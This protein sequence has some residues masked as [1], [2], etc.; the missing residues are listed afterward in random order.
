M[1]RRGR[2]LALV[3]ISLLWPLFQLS[4]YFGHDYVLCNRDSD[5]HETRECIDGLC[6]TKPEY[7]RCGPPSAGLPDCPSETICDLEVAVCVS[8]NEGDTDVDGGDVG[9]D[10]TDMGADDALEDSGVDT[11]VED[12]C[13]VG[14]PCNTNSQCQRWEECVTG[15]CIAA[16][17]CVAEDQPCDTVT[18][19]TE[20]HAC[21]LDYGRC[22]ERC[23]QTNPLGCDYGRWC[24]PATIPTETHDGVC[25]LGD[26]ND[27]CFNYEDCLEETPFACDVGSGPDTGTCVAF[28]R[29][30]SFCL[31][32]GSRTLAESCAA[33]TD[34]TLSCVAGLR[35]FEGI[36][37][38]P[39]S[40]DD[41]NPESGCQGDPV[42]IPVF[43]HEGANQAG[44]CGVSCEAFSLGQCD[45]DSACAFSVGL[46]SNEATAWFCRSLDSAL[47]VVD[48]G[49]DCSLADPQLDRCV[50]EAYCQ[51]ST[52]DASSGT[53]VQYC[54]PSGAVETGFGLC[55]PLPGGPLLGDVTGSTDHGSATAYHSIEE[56]TASLDVWE[57]VSGAEE[58]LLAAAAGA[59]TTAGYA[60]SLVTHF[61]GSDYAVTLIQDN[62][63][64]GEDEPE[65][66]S[67]LV[68]YNL[69]SDN[70]DLFVAEPGLPEVG[71]VAPGAATDVGSVDL[72]GRDLGLG[73]HA[74]ATNGEDDWSSFVWLPPETVLG[75]QAFD[76]VAMG[77][78]SPVPEDPSRRF[79]LVAIP[80]E[81][82]EMI[83]DTVIA[84]VIHASVTTPNM[85]VNW[86]GVAFDQ[87]L[88]R[89]GEVT[90]EWFVS[91]HDPG[92]VEATIRL[93]LLWGAGGD[94]S[95]TESL[96]VPIPSV[97][98]V[99]LMN[100]ADSGDPELAIFEAEE[101]SDESTLAWRAIN[102]TA[103]DLTFVRPEVPIV[104]DAGLRAPVDGF[105]PMDAGDYPVTVRRSND[106][107]GAETGSSAPL[108]AEGEVTV[109]AA[110]A[111]QPIVAIGLTHTRSG[112]PEMRLDTVTFAAPSL[113]VAED[114]IGLV[115][116][117][118][119][120]D[121]AGSVIVRRRQEFSCA[122]LEVH[123]VGHCVPRD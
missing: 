71:I 100:N 96:I 117:I 58:A 70:A 69:G 122:V 40:Y 15:C 59:T 28:G 51:P 47:P 64:T 27:G 87:N 104:L 21:E 53:C 108:L 14:T 49:A 16:T 54:D 109:P 72:T 18:F 98:T 61:D 93:T 78:H 111:E 39:C 20:S 42:C 34:T 76:V 97:V 118:N 60:Y 74:D 103:A 123:G 73:F 115:R 113:P 119:W 6:L 95:L 33:E 38:S 24:V 2:R 23:R 22:G 91:T 110:E 44:I 101:A 13:E 55:R 75:G 107:R 45:A 89:F 88:L 25:L 50:E 31:E 114:G 19:D 67:G 116:V 43:D 4:C 10:S 68:F 1:T 77:Q 84:R 5:C 112:A 63:P 26:C 7:H 80:V 48:V 17:V 85:S 8:T 11:E 65:V 94:E 32:D 41:S 62:A 37:V 30:S 12:H 56:G 105:H 29:G 81:L 121:G 82:P 36:C 92:D 66:R 46:V 99:V 52:G 106:V 90:D 102:A 57:L 83:D 120:A 3:S 79:Q 35:C 9:A 86:P